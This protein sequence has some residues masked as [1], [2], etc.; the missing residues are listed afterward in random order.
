MDEDDD[1][2]G[3]IGAGARA[4]WRWSVSRRTPDDVWA[5]AWLR[6]ARSVR[7]ATNLEA[8]PGHGVTP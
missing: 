6:S 7:C 5:S 3:A 4:I 8:G 2:G 1:R